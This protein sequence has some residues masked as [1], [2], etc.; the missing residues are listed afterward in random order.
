M[1]CDRVDK[2]K[3]RA[4]LYVSKLNKLTEAELDQLSDI[5]CDHDLVF[6]GYVGGRLVHRCRTCGRLQ[7]I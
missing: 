2:R 7:Q 5:L 4:I 3:L 1:G 6:Y